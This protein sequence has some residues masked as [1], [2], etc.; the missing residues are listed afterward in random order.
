VRQPHHPGLRRTVQRGP[1]AGRPDA[2]QELLGEIKDILR[3]T[4]PAVVVYPHPNEAHVDHWA[5]SNF[6]SAALEELRRDEPDWTPPEEWYYLV[7]RGDWPAPK[8][9]RPTDRLLPPAPLTGGMTAWHERPLT[10]EQVKLKGEALS[11]YRSQTM[12]MRRYL[13]SFVRSNEL[14]GTIDRVSLPAAGVA[15]VFAGLGPGHPP[16]R[17]LSWAQVI[18]DPKGDTLAREVERGADVTSV[19]AARDEGMLYLAA[20]TAAKPKRPVV[21]RFYARGFHTGTGWGDVAGVVVSPEGGV[22]VEAW[23]STTGRDQVKADI[24]STWVRVAIPLDALGDPESVMVNVETRAE[25]V[26]VDRSA[27]RPIALDGR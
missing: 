2:G 18:T 22:T 5:L 23:P 26:L 20:P 4:R 9:Y 21:I 1:Q 7:H 19:W 10:E 11:A 25:G 3:E 15:S 8:G 13:H 6:V 16:W 12:L 17:D 14:F 24:Q 27:W